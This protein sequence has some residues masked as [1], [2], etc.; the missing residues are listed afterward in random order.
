MA[1]QADKIRSAITTNVEQQ[2]AAMSMMEGENRAGRL[3]G[4]LIDLYSEQL[5]L[6]AGFLA[7]TGSLKGASHKARI[8]REINDQTKRYIK[9]FPVL[10]AEIHELRER[11]SSFKTATAELTVQLRDHFE[12]ER[13]Q[14]FVTAREHKYL[15][16][17]Y[18]EESNIL[19]RLDADLKLQLDSAT[20]VCIA[21][22]T[23]KIRTSAF[24]EAVACS[25]A[26]RT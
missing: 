17:L 9:E 7:Y 20:E 13:Q 22:Y 18:E 12:A 5:I 14:T 6:K 1:I 2:E 8:T 19:D 21:L 23:K 16:Q 4:A 24:R 15:C 11:I 3:R 10:K 25:Q 26:I